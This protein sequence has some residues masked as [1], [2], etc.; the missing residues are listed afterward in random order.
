M[1]CRCEARRKGAPAS[2][3]KRQLR[4]QL[5]QHGPTTAMGALGMLQGWDRPKHAPD[6]VM[7]GINALLQVEFVLQLQQTE[8]V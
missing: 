7:T 2:R 1:H 6:G 3:A 5:R 8:V 4:A